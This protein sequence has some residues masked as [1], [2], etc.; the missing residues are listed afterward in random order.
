M[1]VI[2]FIIVATI[3]LSLIAG[4]ERDSDTGKR[5]W[6][7]RVNQF[8][9]LFVA[10]FVLFFVASAGRNVHRRLQRSKSVS[11][12]TEV[13]NIELAFTKLLSD[14]GRSSLKALL[15]PVAF[16]EACAWYAREHDA[17]AF[18]AEVAIYT[19]ATY[20]LL[21]NGRDVLTQEAGL[22]DALFGHIQGAL[23]AQV[24]RVLGTSY[25]SEFGTDPWGNP[26]QFFAGPWPDDMGPVLFRRYRESPDSNSTADSLT[27]SI[28]GDVPR[29]QGFPPS[30]KQDIY[31]WSF[32]ANGVSD[33]PRYDPNHEYAP[34]SRQHYRKDASDEYLGGGDDINNWDR[35]MTFMAIYGFW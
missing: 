11:A 3:A 7:S 27:V 15:E 17:D 22:E 9:L 13:S 28:V 20:A 30:S 33:Q 35:N 2:V 16:E 26:Y 29:Q 10:A 6:R 12:I 4:M 19:R 23:N 34:P 5:V 18:E 24:V 25:M 31:L 8:T 32:G 14:A 21:R 1:Y